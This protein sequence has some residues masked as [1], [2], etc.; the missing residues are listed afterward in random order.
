MKI[1]N[2]LLLTLI[3]LGCSQTGSNEEINYRKKVD[4]D[5]RFIGQGLTVEV[6]DKEYDWFLPDLN[7]TAQKSAANYQYPPDNGTAEYVRSFRLYDDTGYVWRWE[8]K[9]EEIYLVYL[10]K[11]GNGYE[12]R[13]LHNTHN[14]T[15]DEAILAI[16][17][18][19]EFNF[20][21]DPFRVE[22]WRIE[23]VDDQYEPQPFSFVGMYIFDKEEFTIFDGRIVTLGWNLFK[24]DGSGYCLEYSSD[25]SCLKLPPAFDQMLSDKNITLEQ[26][27]GVPVYATIKAVLSETGEIK[28]ILGAKLVKVNEDTDEE[29]IIA[30]WPIPKGYLGA[31]TYPFT[32]QFE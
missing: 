22:K 18:D 13:A 14:I 30:S 5:A 4:K 27:I 1:T 7:S 8:H 32:P 23:G 24:R 3:I 2:C 17:F 11:G 12:I 16:Y 19:S 20:Y 21:L 31:G 26:I 25:D 10:F 28:S 15:V 9:G 29:T 6:A